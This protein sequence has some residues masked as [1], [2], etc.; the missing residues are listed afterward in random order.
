MEEAAPRLTH[1]ECRR[2]FGPELHNAYEP[3]T[4]A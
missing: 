4:L 3:P 1:A 2:G